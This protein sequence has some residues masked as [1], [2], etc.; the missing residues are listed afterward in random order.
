MQRG[1]GNIFIYINLKG[2]QQIT[3]KYGSVSKQF[4]VCFERRKERSR[5]VQDGGKKKSAG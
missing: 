4:D 3:E 2:N 5:L 1:K